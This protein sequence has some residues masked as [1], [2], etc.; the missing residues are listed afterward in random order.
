MRKDIIRTVLRPAW[1]YGQATRFECQLIWRGWEAVEADSESV[2]YRQPV[3]GR[4]CIV[5]KFARERSARPML[6]L[7]TEN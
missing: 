5:T 6:T 7:T 4:R 1:N 2:V 3:S